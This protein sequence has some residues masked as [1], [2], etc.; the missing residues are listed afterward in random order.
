MK[1]LELTDEQYSELLR[2]LGATLTVDGLTAA[3]RGRVVL[4]SI[5]GREA[6]VA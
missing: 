4:E 5:L 6:V 3:Q 1:T 2:E